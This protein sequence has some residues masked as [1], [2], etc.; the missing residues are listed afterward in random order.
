MM[1]LCIRLFILI[2]RLIDAKVFREITRKNN[3]P[4]KRDTCLLA[5]KVSITTGSF[6][7]GSI[8]LLMRSRYAV[9]TKRPS[10]S[11]MWVTMSFKRFVTDT[12]I[13]VR[14]ENERSDLIQDKQ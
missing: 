4:L 14:N 12:D 8:S 7:R 1:D 9:S 11:I 13:V 10:F 6:K 3:L 5:F 2:S